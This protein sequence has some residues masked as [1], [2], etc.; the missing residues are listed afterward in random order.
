[1]V[2]PL[3]L[4]SLGKRFCFKVAARPFSARGSFDVQQRGKGFGCRAPA[5][6]TVHVPVILQ[7]LPCEG[8]IEELTDPCQPSLRRA[9]KVGPRLMHEGKVALL[10]PC[11][12]LSRAACPC[13]LDT[14]QRNNAS[15]A[16]KRGNVT[17]GPAVSSAA[18]SRIRPRVRSRWASRYVT[19]SGFYQ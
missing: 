8:A 9:P 17:R 18:T 1:M 7:R 2:R 13:G 5:F 15:S 11:L 16:S 14:N 3:Q 6:S 4:F 12:T 10:P 19:G